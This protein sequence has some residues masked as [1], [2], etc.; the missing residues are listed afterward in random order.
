[1]LVRDCV[2]M[3]L[4][5]AVE[6]H[7]G[8]SKLLFITWVMWDCYTIPN[9]DVIEVAKWVLINRMGTILQSGRYLACWLQERTIA[10]AM[11]QQMA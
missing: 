11:P 3:Q 6:F 9:A 1:M 8:G 10:T 5:V 4:H 7:P 2:Q